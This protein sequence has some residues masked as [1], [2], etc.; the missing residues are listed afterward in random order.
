MLQWECGVEIGHVFRQTQSGCLSEV[1]RLRRS[2]GID[3][4]VTLRPVDM[5]SSSSDTEILASVLC[6]S[7]AW[8][9]LPVDE[10]ETMIWGGA[11]KIGVGARELRT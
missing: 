2:D 3:A 5:H 7:S 10:A 8:E 11:T 6:G 1:V 9:R 4:K